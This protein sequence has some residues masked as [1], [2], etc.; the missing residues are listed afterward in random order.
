MQEEQHT[1]KQQ[2]NNERDS[3]H[4]RLPLIIAVALATGMIIGGEFLGKTPK[5]SNLEI[6]TGKLEQVIESIEGY[7][8]DSVDTQVL[9]DQA[10]E[11]VVKELDP[12]TSYIPV[13]DVEVVSAQLDDGFEGVGI[14]FRVFRDTIKVVAVTEDGPSERAG[15][16]SGDK[17]VYVDGESVAGPGMNSGEVVRKL[18]GQKG[19]KVSI[20]VSRKGEEK[21]LYF[22]VTRDKIPTASV[23]AVYMIDEETGYIKVDRFGED[24]FEGFEEGVE[25]LQ[26]AGMKKL[27]LDL[28][29]NGGGYM[30]QAVQMVDAFLPKDK[31]IVYTESREKNF[32]EHEY[33]KNEGVLQET[34]VVVLVNEYSA[35]ASEIVSGALQDHDRALLVGRRTFGKGLVQRQIRLRDNSMLRL[36]V[37]RYYTP[38]GRCIQ[39][40]YE[41]KSAYETEL[42][43][44][45]IHGEMFQADSIHFNDSLI[46]KTVNGRTVYGGGGIMPDVFI[47]MDTSYY[48]NY[49][50]EIL[51]RG[52]IEDYFIDYANGQFESLNEMGLNAFIAQYKVPAIEMKEFAT[53]ARAHG[54]PFNKEQYKASQKAL[55]QRIKETIAR[56]VWGEEGRLKVE[57][58]ADPIFIKACELANTLNQVS[59]S[60]EMVIK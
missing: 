57:N 10:I 51:I 9:T 54:V 43:R 17:L 3:F 42:E 25:K 11:A 2:P 13:R 15:I 60:N 46:Y 27:L 19:T 32:D 47:G 18:R 40:P 29:D 34:P 7:Y 33:S 6:N 56:V 49:Y 50:Q 22:S 1:E 35:S 45:Y 12:H 36:T 23:S 5:G 31:L 55:R 21:P 58:A 4:I 39:K 37:S 52:L 41:D 48:T 44:R 28:T 8:V 30:G 38:S 53:Y 20:G 26:E 14:E 24:A 59:L 16:Q